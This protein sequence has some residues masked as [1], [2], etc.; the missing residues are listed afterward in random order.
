MPW[1]AIRGKLRVDRS[2][3]W[4]IHPCYL[5]LPARAPGSLQSQLLPGRLHNP[6][7]L[8]V[9]KLGRAR[10]ACYL[11]DNF[12]RARGLKNLKNI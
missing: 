10:K 4:F 9:S 3:D 6:W 12:R 5:H 11:G 1:I 2:A 8:L 7:G